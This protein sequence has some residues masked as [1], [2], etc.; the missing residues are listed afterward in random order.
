MIE[1]LSSK[2][3]PYYNKLITT[4]YNKD[5]NEDVNAE[6]LRLHN[7]VFYNDMNEINK[8]QSEKSTEIFKDWVAEIKNEKQAHV[9]NKITPAN[10]ILYTHRASQEAIFGDKTTC[11]LPE[12]TKQADR[13]YF[14]IK[15]YNNDGK[16]YFDT[17]YKLYMWWHNNSVYA[18]NTDGPNDQQN[19]QSHDIVNDP[20]RLFD[21]AKQ[22]HPLLVSR[23][24]LEL[25]ADGDTVLASD[26]DAKKL[27]ASAAASILINK[28]VSE[29]MF[30][31]RYHPRDIVSAV[32][33]ITLLAFSTGAIALNMFI[34][35]AI[36]PTL[37]LC[38]PEKFKGTSSIEKYMKAHTDQHYVKSMQLKASAGVFERIQG[39]E[40][41]LVLPKVDSDNNVLNQ[42]GPQ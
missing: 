7:L 6:L 23:F 37:Y 16:I 11:E 31:Q 32:I 38:L 42:P 24:I 39:M 14:N 21:K 30:P 40:S 41:T 15:Y 36:I 22:H 17:S 10:L 27:D 3:Y 8:S 9:L 18:Q 20:L 2:D 33:L 34:A 1:L 13:E 4:Q 35:I 19:H 5:A 25:R 28:D 29:L 12:G 26:E